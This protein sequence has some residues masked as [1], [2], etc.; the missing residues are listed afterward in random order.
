MISFMRRMINNNV[1]KIFLWI[2]LFM[3]ALGSGISLFDFRGSQDWV[4]KVYSETIT[5][6][7]FQMKLKQA[8]QQQEMLRQRGYVFTKQD[9]QKQTVESSVGGL[10]VD[11]LRNDISLRAPKSH[12]NSE[13]KKQIQQFPSYLLKE[14]GQLNE[15]V[16]NQ[17]AAPHTV[18]DFVSQVETDVKNKL[19][20][21]I[22]DAS[23][24]VPEFEMALQYT[25][26]FANKSYSYVVLPYQ[27][28]LASAK[29]KQPLEETLQKFYKKAGVAEKFKTLEKRAGTMWT[30]DISN[31]SITISDSDAKQFYDK[32]KAARYLITPAEMQIRSLLIKVEAGKEADAKTKIEGIREEAEKDPSQFEEMVRRLSEDKSAAKGGLSVFFKKD[33]SKMNKMVTETAFEFL[34]QDGQISAPI[35]TEQGYELIQRVARNAAKYKE[36]SS[37]QSEIKKELSLERFKKRFSQDASRVVT[38]AKYHP[39]ALVKFVERYKGSK[40]ELPMDVRKSGIEYT[41]LF[42]TEQGRSVTFFDKDKGVI[43]TCTKVEKSFLPELSDVQS[44]VLSMYYEQKAIDTMKEELALALKDAK[45]M[46]LEN[47][48][49]KY[50]A[51]IH[52]ATFTNKNGTIEQSAILKEPEVQAKIKGMQYVGALAGV[53]TKSEGILLRLDKIASLSKELFNDQK[54]HLGKTMLYTKIYQ[55]KEGFIASLYR[56]ANINN[57]I[58]I[59]VELSSITKE[60]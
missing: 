45:K 9:A 41:N 37:V 43:L 57:K 60:V 33:D 5:K 17:V 28:Y 27:K 58:E 49:E 36:F 59:K 4:I 3:M 15:D 42:T 38:G 32:N 52:S 53:E 21:A 39:E 47:V 6:P 18:D 23:V 34:A 46:T 54:G 29:T 44:K 7:Q 22:V 30:F 48:A 13:V 20:F 10:L 26:E 40:V 19:L 12:I 31:Y 2:F 1:Y 16:F 56:T 51:S 14:D 24:Y 8:S 55:N 50:G 35:K 11:N 25:T